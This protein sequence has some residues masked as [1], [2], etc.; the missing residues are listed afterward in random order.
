MGAAICASFASAEADMRLWA[1]AWVGSSVCACAR[2][3]GDARV[4]THLSVACSSP[5]VC[6][7]VHVC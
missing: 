2:A 6:A 7:S 1:S 3:C 5:R 4:N